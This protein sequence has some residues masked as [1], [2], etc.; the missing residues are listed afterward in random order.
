MEDCLVI[1]KKL[2]TLKKC[3]AAKERYIIRKRKAT[4]GPPFSKIFLITSPPL[5]TH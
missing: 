4:I 2:L 1:F 3:G 5:E